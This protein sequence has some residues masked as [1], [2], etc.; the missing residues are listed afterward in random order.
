M[1]NIKNKT[2]LLNAAT[3]LIQKFKA[4]E[5]LLELLSEGLGWVCEEEKSRR[6]VSSNVF[7]I[8][9]LIDEVYSPWVKCPGNETEAIARD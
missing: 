8:K 4:P 3:I 1:S 5:I 9:L 6:E 2:C 7:V